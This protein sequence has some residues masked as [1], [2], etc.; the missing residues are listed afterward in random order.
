MIFAPIILLWIDPDVPPGASI[1]PQTGL[2]QWAIGEDGPE[3]DRITVRVT[4]D[5]LD[6]RSAAHAL[7]R[8]LSWRRRAS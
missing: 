8:L 5:A 3:H 6:A 1:D 2:F 7:S 4:D